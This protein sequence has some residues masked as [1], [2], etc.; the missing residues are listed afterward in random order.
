MN[1]Q[2]IITNLN[3]ILSIKKLE[4]QK[5]RVDLFYLKLS[6]APLYLKSPL[7]FLYKHRLVSIISI[8]VG[9]KELSKIA[10]KTVGYLEAEDILAFYCTKNQLKTIQNLMNA[11]DTQAK[12][13]SAFLLIH[14][15]IAV[16]S[17]FLISVNKSSAL[18]SILKKNLSFLIEVL[19][20]IFYSELIKISKITFKKHAII[21]ND[22][23]A[24]P[25]AFYSFAKQNSSKITYL[26][27]GHVSK[28]FPPLYRFDLA[29]LFG[30]KSLDTYLEIGR[31]PNS[32]ALTGHNYFTASP[33]KTCPDIINVTIFPNLIYE[34]RLMK[35]IQGLR[36][37]PVIN[38]ISIKPHPLHNLSETFKQKI[39]A[40]KSVSILKFN[41]HYQSQTDLGIAANTSMHIELLSQ[42]IN[43]AYYD[44]LDEIEHD[45]YSFVKNES[46][47]EIKNAEDINSK[48]INNFYQ[49]S[50]WKEKIAQFDC[51]FQSEDFLNSE[52][53]KIKKFF[54]SQNNQS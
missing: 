5:T 41:D 7:V 15:I 21:A 2:Q 40:I 12:P 37:N 48:N 4:S 38:Q 18:K 27:H 11:I 36:D 35:L 32:Y 54:S 45:Y 53:E 9:L 13:K 29:V 46:V 33:I 24:Q 1:V 6:K 51:A 49:S 16:F 39:Q 42:G 20:Y 50:E 28:Y 3:C 23:S 52:I 14:T 19:R 22:H 26:Q 30:K 44:E 8:L 43:T 17:T 10:K 31:G 34:E 25:L 47:V